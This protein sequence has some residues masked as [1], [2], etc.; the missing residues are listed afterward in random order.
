[1]SVKTL[2]REEVDVPLNQFDEARRP[3]RKLEY[4]EKTSEEL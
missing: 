1:M 3:A 2:W 4:K